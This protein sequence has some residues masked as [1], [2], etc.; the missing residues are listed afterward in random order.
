MLLRDKKGPVLQVIYYE[1]TH[2]DIEN[3]FV[4]KMLRYNILILLFLYYL[5]EATQFM[6]K[7]WKSFFLLL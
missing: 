1:T 5:S 4:G 3:F 6:V 7:E 2:I